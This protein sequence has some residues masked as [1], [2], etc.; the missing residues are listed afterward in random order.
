[1][2]KYSESPMIPSVHIEVALAT[3]PPA[4]LD[5]LA[6]EDGGRRHTAIWEIARGLVERLSC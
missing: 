3:A 5:G 1:M 2:T 4:L 6:D